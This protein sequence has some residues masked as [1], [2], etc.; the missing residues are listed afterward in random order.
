[1]HKIRKHI[2]IAL[3]YIT[4]FYLSVGGPVL[5]ISFMTRY[6]WH[7][8]SYVQ[9]DTLGDKWHRNFSELLLGE[10]RGRQV[11]KYLALVWINV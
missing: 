2:H 10:L 5:H 7:L 11:T 1:M 3:H 4:T 6:A 8:L 9:V